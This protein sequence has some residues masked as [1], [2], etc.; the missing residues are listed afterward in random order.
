MENILVAIFGKYTLS[1]VVSKL[2]SMKLVLQGCVNQ[3]SANF[4]CKEPDSEY[5]KLVAH[6]VSFA[7]TQLCHCSTKEAIDK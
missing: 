7:A 1:Q 2:Y 5:F 6:S 3:G 4:F